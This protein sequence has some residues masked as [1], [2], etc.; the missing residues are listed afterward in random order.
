MP[1]D[2]ERRVH[3]IAGST[4]KTA[5]AVR[6]FMATEIHRRLDSGDADVGDL[7][8][9]LSA[10]AGR[11][12]SPD[13]ACRLILSVFEAPNGELWALTGQLA[14][15]VVVGG[16]SDNPAFVTRVF[17]QGGR[18][19]PLFL[20]CELKLCKPSK[21]AFETV[22]ARL[23]VGPAEIL[24]IDDT[25]ANVEQARGMGWDA[26][27]FVSNAALLADLANRGLP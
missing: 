16:F 14:K 20:S 19:N 1:F 17:P 12:V 5:E 21:Q 15:T 26:I 11:T 25:A 23:G 2:R 18:L 22:A 13:E 6:A 7:A 4:G 10:F 24:F 27:Q 3:A 9:E 8:D